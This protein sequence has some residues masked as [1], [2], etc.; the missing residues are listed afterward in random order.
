[1]LVHQTAQAVD[2]NHNSSG[3]HRRAQTTTPIGPATGRKRGLHVYAGFAH[4]WLDLCM[5]ARPVKA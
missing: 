1:M 3:G 2:A 5:L 4:H